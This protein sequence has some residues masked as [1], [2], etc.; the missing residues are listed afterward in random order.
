MCYIFKDAESF[1]EFKARFSPSRTERY[2]PFDD[3]YLEIIAEL[4]AGEYTFY[5]RKYHYVDEYVPFY[6]PGVEVL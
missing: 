3:G 2:A 4:N 1:E 5:Y 6:R